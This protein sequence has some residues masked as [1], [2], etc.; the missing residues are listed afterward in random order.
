MSVT[1]SSAPSE[2]DLPDDVY[3]SQEQ[4]RLAIFAL[5]YTA[6][7]ALLTAWLFGAASY[8]FI[9]HGEDNSISWYGATGESFLR[10][11]LPAAI[12]MPLFQTP[13]ILRRTLQMRNDGRLE[14]PLDAELKDLPWKQWA[15]ILALVT[16]GIWSSIAMLGFTI[17]ASWV[18]NAQLGLWT[19]LAFKVVYTTIIGMSVAV[20]CA[21]AAVRIS[22]TSNLL[23]RVLDADDTTND[24]TEMESHTPSNGG[25]PRPALDPQLGRGRLEVPTEPQHKLVWDRWRTGVRESVLKRT[26]GSVYF[27]GRRRFPFLRRAFI[28]LTLSVLMLTM[29]MYTNS[30]VVVLAAVLIAPLMTPILGLTLALVT[31]RPSRQIE[32]VLLVAGAAGYIIVLTALT[33][34]V[35]PEPPV[36]PS[37]LLDYTDPRLPDL[38][39]AL[40]AGTVGMYVLVH[41]EAS[42]ALPGVAV[43]ISLEPPIA[44]TG[45]MLAWG[46]DERAI[47]AFLMFTLNLAA[48]LAAGSLVLIVSGFLPVTHWR[49]L[50]HRVKV[51]LTIAA[52]A[53]V[54][55]AY[56]LFRL[57]YATLRDTNEHEAVT[58][59]LIPWA[60]AQEFEI[61]K[62]EI[63]DDEVL[64]D[65]S[66]PEQPQNVDTLAQDVADALGR[67]ADVQVHVYSYTSYEQHVEP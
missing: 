23:E 35:L 60:E 66:G 33:S 20:M 11:Y 39:I 27:D 15:I 18:P 45:M 44:A 37:V 47:G 40:L 6:P 9:V 59:V 31:G 25:S 54:F 3:V 24:A 43:A 36:V 46:Y 19:G 21:I 55:V 8:F 38:L 30:A 67:P 57:S 28:L 4:R 62:M 53:V 61:L 56:P 41:T 32:S 51:G 26:E 2:S 48:I 7:P 65:L 49:Q 16:G 12:I 22:P 5:R 64:I 42:T 29:G 1:S 14:P 10:V 13:V 63:D 17:I 58:S 34:I 50:R 52:L